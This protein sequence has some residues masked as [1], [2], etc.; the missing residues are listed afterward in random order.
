MASTIFKGNF[1]KT[2]KDNLS[3]NDQTEIQQGTVDPTST[4]VTAPIGS[5]YFNTSTGDIYKK[6]DAGLTTSWSKLA[7]GDNTGINYITNSSAEGSTSGWATYA[8][9]A[10]TAPVDGTGGS[11]NVTWTRTTSNPLRGNAS[12]LFTKDAANRQGQGVSYDFILSRADRAKAMQ[13][14][15]D[16]EIP[17]GTYANG[18]LR[19]YVYEAVGGVMY[20]LAPTDIYSISVSG[21]W[22]GVFQTGPVNAAYRL[23][24]HTSSTSASA[25]TVKF[26]NITLTPVLASTGTLITD[27]VT[28]PLTIAGAT[29]NPTKG[30]T[31]I[32]IAR[33]RRVGDSLEFRYDYQQTGAGA[34]GS[35]SYLFPIPSGL[36]IDLNKM[37]AG[38]GSIGVVGS[39]EVLSGASVYNG[40]VE[41]VSSTQ[42]RIQV[43]NEVT[44]VTDVNSAFCGLGTASTRYSFAALVP[45]TGWSSSQQASSDTSQ[46]AVGAAVRIVS[47]SPQSIPNATNTVMVFSTVDG[48][49]TGSYNSGTG[50]YTVPVA[51]DYKVSSQ[52]QLNVTVASTGQFNMRLLKN[53]AVVDGVEGNNPITF[54]S[55]TNNINVEWTFQ[56][57]KAGD[58]L[59][60]QVFQNNGGSRGVYGNAIF[61]R[62]A[63]PEQ[64]V[65]SE[66]V[67]VY[68]RRISS[69][70]QTIPNNTNTNFVYDVEDI[71][72]HGAYNSSTGL[73]TAPRSGYLEYSA[74]V[75]GSSFTANTG[76]V[77]CFLTKNGTSLNSANGLSSIGASTQ[78]GALVSGQISVVTGDSIRIQ[79]FQNNGA[80]RDLNGY[81]SFIMRGL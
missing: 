67:R 73:F 19:V 18:D 28:Y 58:T 65:V 47:G 63:A 72:T 16:Y 74:Y 5:L 37:S 81:V 35:G 17:S 39:A 80:S 68:A 61:E 51:G 76:Q 56:N 64:I 24:I 14:S 26:D 71:D 29:T 10:G 75:E 53:G 9:A 3:L 4:A 7:I 43:G 6:N 49:K 45:I 77:I 1:I 13:V 50:V 62:L 31:S 46:R 55:S 25:Y 11:A 42:L 2:L 69:N 52:L 57:C 27:W 78:D 8:D 23:I 20:E 15:F 70:R 48:D 66:S 40:V 38:P 12:F 44:A 33:Y 59:S 22:S 30:T 79:A 32:D 36:T 54:T 41:A 21:T 34:N 60:V